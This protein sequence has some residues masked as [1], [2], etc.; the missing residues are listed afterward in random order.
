MIPYPY[1]QSADFLYLTGIT[2][3]YAL[4]VLDASRTYRLFVADADAWRDTWDG[5]R[6]GPAAAAAVFGADE[7]LPMS[8]VGIGAGRGGRG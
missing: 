4:A 1:R 7:A 8:Q 2:Q 6:L 5:A 3:P